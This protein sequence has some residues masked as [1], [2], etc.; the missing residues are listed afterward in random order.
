MLPAAD[1]GAVNNVAEP[2][3][4]GLE[5]LEAVAASIAWMDAHHRVIGHVFNELLE[6]QVG[7]G[8]LVIGI[9]V[10]MIISSILD[11]VRTTYAEL[12]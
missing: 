2:A 5:L 3:H 1:D 11:I 7:S 6:T 10:Q 4:L 12:M 8:F 9:G